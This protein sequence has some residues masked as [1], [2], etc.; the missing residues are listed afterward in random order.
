[1]KEVYIGSIIRKRRQELGL[2]QEQ[3][4]RGICETVTLSRI[5][6]GKQTPSRSKLN[7]LLQRL[8]M[9]GERYYALLSEQEMKISNL[10]TEIVSCNV[11]GQREQG[12]KKLDE[13]E[14]MMEADDHLTRQF[15]LRCRALLGR[16]EDGKLVP[17]SFREKQMLLFRAISLTVPHF[18]VQ[19]ISGNLYGVDE[20]KI[21]NQIALVYADYGQTKA[22]VSLYSQL[23]QYLDGHL[24]SLEQTRPMK[25]LISYNYARVLCMEQQN[26]QA[27][28]VAQ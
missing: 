10:Q 25:I 23:L 2:T 21:I 8:G 19:D 11:L 3:L 28:Q 24:Q 9:P 13:L 22:A 4:C 16:W 15:V 7:A 1:M 12:L 6:N 17:Y 18:C 5:E 26:E 27:I 14:Q 20:L